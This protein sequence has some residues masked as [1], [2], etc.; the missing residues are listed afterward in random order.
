MNKS[1]SI[2]DNVMT[3]IERQRVTMRPKWH[4]ML[5]AAAGTVTIGLL[6]TLNAY[7]IDLVTIA[8]RIQGSS[9]PMYG[10]RSRLDDMLTNFPWLLVV[11]AVASFVLLVWLLRRSARLYRVRTVWL[12]LAALLISTTFG[13]LLSHAPFNSGNHQGQPQGSMRGYNTT[14]Q[15]GR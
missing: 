11:A 3:Q 8:I 4:F 2:T 15:Y 6:A 10:A 7:L 13:L 5:L 12:V 14:R 9:R 1:K